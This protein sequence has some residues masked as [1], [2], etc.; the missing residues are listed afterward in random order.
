MKDYHIKK[1][2]SLYFKQLNMI[3]VVNWTTVM[4][5][6]RYMVVVVIV[7]IV[8]CIGKNILIYVV[9]LMKHILITTTIKNWKIGFIRDIKFAMMVSVSY[10]II[11]IKNY[12]TFVIINTMIK[13][14]A[15]NVLQI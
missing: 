6:M 11:N 3:V 13:G 7:V 12:I 4:N 15:L 5:V 1:I 9:H 14:F 8:V 10:A 2:R